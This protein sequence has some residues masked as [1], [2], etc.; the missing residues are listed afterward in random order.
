MTT[1]VTFLTTIVSI[2]LVV[3]GYLV[4]KLLKKKDSF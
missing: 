3:G 4:F 2:F 1:D